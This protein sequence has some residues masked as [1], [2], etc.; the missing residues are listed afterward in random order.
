MEILLSLPANAVSSFDVLNSGR[1]GT[2]YADSG[3]AGT[4]VESG[5]GGDLLMGAKDEGAA[6]PI[7]E[8]LKENPPHNNARFV[9]VELNNKRLEVSR[10]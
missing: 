4:K 5:G 10:S 7:R 2:F 1:D 3:P 6:A 9:E 8:T